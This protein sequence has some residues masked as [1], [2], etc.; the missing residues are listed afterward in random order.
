MSE[1][2]LVG[3]EADNV[4]YP[5]MFTDICARQSSMLVR[6]YVRKL[7]EGQG[8]FAHGYLVKW[9]EK[10]EK[11]P[12]HPFETIGD[13]AVFLDDLAYTMKDDYGDPVITEQQLR[14]AKNYILKGLSVA[15]IEEI[16]GGI[17]YTDGLPEAVEAFKEDEIRQTL[18]SD[19]LWPHI[20]FQIEKLGLDSGAGVPP[21]MW[22]KK[23]GEFVYDPENCPKGAELTGRLKEFDKISAL[24]GCLRGDNGEIVPKEN[25]AVIDDSGSSVKRVLAPVRGAGGLAVGFNVI[26]EDRKEFD[27]YSIPIIMGNSLL[28]FIEI[29]RDPSEATMSKYCE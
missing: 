10:N 4:M 14:A 25:V 3:Y 22:D 18:C 27:K 13:L 19:S 6:H 29:V 23:M 26:G 28:P 15:L 9:M 16:S 21:I 11:D 5:G 1:I 12:D 17:E 7:G 20:A 24:F 8:M 2:V